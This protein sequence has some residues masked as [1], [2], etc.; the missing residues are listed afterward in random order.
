MVL[1]GI[2]LMVG[3]RYATMFLMVLAVTLIGIARPFG[4]FRN[5]AQGLI[6]L[7]FMLLFMRPYNDNDPVPSF[8]DVHTSDQNRGQ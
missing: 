5:R 6:L 4:I 7:A 8:K 1:E 3:Q 2:G